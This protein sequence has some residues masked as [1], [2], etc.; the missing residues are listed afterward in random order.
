MAPP[1]EEAKPA[2][3]APAEEAKA[4]EPEVVPPSAEE[5]KPTASAPA[6]VPVVEEELPPL[7]RYRD[8]QL[9][10]MVTGGQIKPEQAARY[11]ELR[12]FKRRNKPKGHSAV[13]RHHLYADRMRELDELD[14]TITTA[15]SSA[16]ITRIESTLT[17]VDDRTEATLD[18]VIQLRAEIAK[19]VGVVCPP[20]LDKNDPVDVET[21]SRE[22]A[23]LRIKQRLTQERLNVVRPIAKGLE[24]SAIRSGA[25]GVLRSIKVRVGRSSTVIAN[26]SGTTT[27]AQIETRFRAAAGSTNEGDKIVFKFG[28]HVLVPADSLG[29][30]GLS[31][32]ATIEAVIS[33]ELT[34][35]QVK[36][37]GR[38]PIELEVE[39]ADTVTNVKAKIQTAWGIPPDHQQLKCGGISLES[40]TIAATPQGAVF[41]LT[42]IKSKGGKGGKDVD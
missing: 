42:K 32:K 30:C 37:R 8:A 16:A 40:G 38:D 10:G 9:D 23:D 13:G 18:E 7:V 19:V 36:S 3:S 17:R 2:A 12:H 27:I 34:S 24:Q 41:V 21:A 11:K 5:A 28:D 26:V 25:S 6:A 20:A 39:A 29:T 4:A 1:T 35:I 22:A 33:R 15:T 14:R 31:D